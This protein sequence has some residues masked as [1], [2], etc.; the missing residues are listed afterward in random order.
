MTI[1]KQFNP[2]EL[3]SFQFIGISNRTHLPCTD[4]LRIIL[5]V[6]MIHSGTTANTSEVS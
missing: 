5:F 2:S 4:V 3:V 6:L 1:A